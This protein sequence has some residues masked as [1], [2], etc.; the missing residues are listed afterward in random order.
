MSAYGI[1]Q[2]GNEASLQ[3]LIAVVSTCSYK[4]GWGFAIVEMSRTGEHLAGS[5][6]TT[7][8]I[9]AAC[10]DSRFPT[11]PQTVNLLHLF[12]APPADWGLEQWEHWL[13]ECVLEVEKHEAMEWLRFNGAAHFSPAHGPGHYSPYLVRRKP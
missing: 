13:L 9:A 12:A 2:S 10:P 3:R 7:L 5:N 8:Q 11:V 4:P 1:W 6:G